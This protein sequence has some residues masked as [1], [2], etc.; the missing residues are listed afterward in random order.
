MEGGQKKDI[1]LT[2]GLDVKSSDQLV[3]VN[4]PLFQHN[5]QRY[6]GSMLPTSLR[7]EH[8]GYA[9]GWG[10][11]EFELD[12]VSVDTTPTG[13]TVIYNKLNNNPAYIFTIKSDDVSVGQIYFNGEDSVSSGDVSIA[14]DPEDYSIVTLSGDNS[15][16]E[17][18]ITINLITGEISYASSEWYVYEGSYNEALASDGSST[19][20]VVD[21][22][23]WVQFNA[24]VLQAKDATYNDTSLAAYSSCSDSTHTWKSSSGISWEIIH[25]VDTDE[26]TVNGETVEATRDDTTG[27]LSIPYNTQYSGTIDLSAKSSSFYF[28]I[29]DAYVSQSSK[30]ID[31]SNVTTEEFGNWSALLNGDTWLYPTESGSRSLTIQGSVPFWCGVVLS[32]GTQANGSSSVDLQELKAEGG[33]SITPSRAVFSA[34]LYVI[35]GEN[36]LLYD[37]VV[38]G[39]SGELWIGET[40]CLSEYGE[41]TSEELEVQD[42]IHVTLTYCACVFNRVSIDSEYEDTYQYTPMP[43][44]C[45]SIDSEYTDKSI[46]APWL[47]TSTRLSKK[48]KEGA[49]EEYVEVTFEGGFYHEVAWYTSSEEESIESGW[50]L[51]DEN[52]DPD[53]SSYPDVYADEQVIGDGSEYDSYVRLDFPYANYD[54]EVKSESIDG[55]SYICTDTSSEEEIASVMGRSIVD[56][57]IILERSTYDDGE[58]GKTYNFGSTGYLLPFFYS[59]ETG[60]ENDTRLLVNVNSSSSDAGSISEN[61]VTL[62]ITKGPLSGVKIISTVSNNTTSFNKTAGINM[63]Y[64]ATRVAQ[65]VEELRATY[66]A[67]GYTYV[68]YTAKNTG[69][70]SLSVTAYFTRFEGTS[71]VY[72]GDSR[73]GSYTDDTEECLSEY[74]SYYNIEPLSSW[75]KVVGLGDNTHKSSQLKTYLSVCF[76]GLF[77]YDVSLN[78]V[79]E[80]ATITSGTLLSAVNIE[81][82]PVV[83]L[84]EG[85]GFYIDRD[86]DNSSS[87]GV[88]TLFGVHKLNLTKSSS[89]VSN[90]TATIQMFLKPVSSY[91]LQIGSDSDCYIPGQVY[92]GASNRAYSGYNLTATTAGSSYENTSL[93]LSI[94][95]TV[96]AFNRITSGSVSWDKEDGS[97][98]FFSDCLPLA[99]SGITITSITFGSLTN[100]SA[101]NASALQLITLDIGGNSVVLRLNHVLS[102]GEASSVLTIDTAS[103][104]YEGYTFNFDLSNYSISSSGTDVVLSV[105][106]PLFYAI[107]ARLPYQYNYSSSISYDSDTGKYTIDGIEYDIVPVGSYAKGFTSS[108]NIYTFESDGGYSYTWSSE[109]GVATYGIETIETTD[110]GEA[111]TFSID[112]NEQLSFGFILQGV[113]RSNN[114]NVASF[115]DTDISFEYNGGVYTFS[116]DELLNSDSPSLLSFKYTD[117][118]DDSTTPSST[119]F[120]VQD[121]TDAYQFLRQ[122]WETDVS[123]ENFWWIDA[124]TVLELNKTSLV[125]KRKVSSFSDYDSET[126][127]DID[128]WGGDAWKDAAYFPRGDYLD[129]TVARYGVTCA[130]EGA[131]PRFWAVKVSSSNK[132]I[133]TFYTLTGSDYTWQFNKVSVTV[134]LSKVELGKALNSSALTLNTYSQLSATTI[135]YEAKFSGTVIGQHILFGI[136]QDNNFN[137]WALDISTDGTLNAIVQGYGFVGLDGSLTGGEIPSAFFDPS[138][139]F[140]SIVYPIDEIEQEDIEYVSSY[141]D[142]VSLD[143][144]GKVVGDCTQ[145]WYITSNLLNI[146]SHLT[147]NGESW[148]V[149]SLPITSNYICDYGSPSYGKRVISDASL[150]DKKLTELVTDDSFISEVEGIL[151]GLVT[152][153]I[154]GISPKVTYSLYL[155]QTCGQYA[156]VHY[157]SDTPNKQKDLTREDTSDNGFGEQGYEGRAYN[158]IGLA[159]DSNKEQE[160]D[161]IMAGYS[162]DFS[163]NIKGL[164][165]SVTVDK[166]WANSSLGMIVLII[167]GMSALTSTLSGVLDTLAVNKRANS[168]SASDFGKCFT[169]NFLYN[170]DNL[171]TMDKN[172]LGPVPTVQSAI[173]ASCSLDMFYSTSEGQK[174]QAGPGW[175]QHNMVAQCVA[176]SVTSCQ[177]ELQQIGMLWI[178]EGIGTLSAKYL[179]V[180]AQ[181]TWEAAVATAEST[182]EMTIMSTNSGWAIAVGIIAAAAVAYAA[183]GIYKVFS[184]FSDQ[185]IHSITGG[186]A[187]VEVK[188][189]ASKHDYTIEGKHKYGQKSEVFMWPCFGVD[190]DNAYTDETAEAVLVNHEWKLK[191]PLTSGTSWMGGEYSDIG[192]MV[193]EGVTTHTQADEV[194]ND[195]DGDV[196]YLISNLKGA[197]EEKTLPSDMACVIGSNSFLSPVPFRNE[198]ISASDPVFPTAPFQDYIID[199][200]WELSRTAAVGMTTWISCKDTKIIDGEASN[201]VVSDDF[202][203]VACPYTAIEVKRGCEQKYIR[204]WAITSN[205]IALNQSGFNCCYDEKAYHA[206]DGYGYRIVRWVGADGMNKEGAASQYSFIVNNRFKRSNKMPPNTFIGNFKGDPIIAL[207][208]TGEDWVSNQVTW[209]SRR[210]GLEA[211]TIGEDK[212]VR[213]YAVPVFSELVSTLP[214]VVKTISSI[215]LSV[216]DGITSLTTENRDLQSAY[217]APVSI[218]FAIGQDKY[219]FTDEYLCSLKVER[220]VTVVENL[221]P[222]LGLTYL[223]STPYEAYLY[224]QATRQY[225]T[226]AGGTSLTAVDTL[227][228]F[229]DVLYGRYDFVNQEVAIPCVATFVRLDKHVFDDEDERDNTIVPRLKEGSV[230]GEIAPPIETIYNMRSGFKTIS[231]PSGLC[232]QG[233][234]RCI[235]NRFVYSDYMKDQIINNAGNWSR[236]PREKYHPFR[237][238]GVEYERVD[239]DITSYISGWTHNPFLLVT[240]PLGVSS[241]VDCMFEWEITFAWPV[242]MDELYKEKQYACVNIMA[243]TFTPG[244]KVIPDRPTHVFLYRGL[245]TRTGNYGYYSF[246]YQSRC[247]AGN[248]ERLH[249]WSDQY[250]AVSGLR[251]E[252]KPV[253]EKRTEILTQQV[254]VQ[255]MQE[256]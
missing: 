96:A 215:N 115:S 63:W 43:F 245:F 121:V 205:A 226:Y 29:I 112:T 137:Q 158:A 98:L 187:K 138:I 191:V 256:I 210:V 123:V 33:G 135:A 35:P 142:F 109:T 198:N 212:D 80:D 125:V 161:A 236:V 162:D 177:W 188:N 34:S 209:G 168:I 51:T 201:I 22:L 2:S 211:G 150:W 84:V 10:V 106:V 94:K 75:S 110:V 239:E 20:N 128:D 104:T 14:H 141:K 120:A 19:L 3:P 48:V 47:D 69:W 204:P 64:R 40:E 77:Q 49:E 73:L 235:I 53:P 132:L 56:I 127:V 95:G 133:I 32:V 46:G 163:F 208:T 241:E 173:G 170:M 222:T 253:T 172:I 17:Y 183:A 72:V 179:Y 147:W 237:D 182:K 180:A 100:D 199:K 30:Y 27:E 233:P 149:V 66:E 71:T 62:E 252:Y 57:S 59:T 18:E 44:T 37:G 197:R 82:S 140:S 67:E 16:H 70:S 171:A 41:V 126:E 225:Y 200:G 90:T 7:Y 217:K 230:I 154:W 24:A 54:I 234:N 228:R 189:A 153:H 130:Y 129:N 220:G 92:Y 55:G 42:D 117:T 178:I 65:F 76:N 5:R 8:N 207:T 240:S 175:V 122:A 91:Y 23:S 184:D 36:F 25:D 45:D 165:Q 250:I 102:E 124:D 114:V 255:D 190:T 243:E 113:Y 52:G 238:Y 50:Y 93:S 78:D 193:F 174:I 119:T 9:A 247:G 181:I 214:A 86:Y 116:Y 176:Q 185:L 99:T 11:Y 26:T 103:I 227:E 134:A 88:C 192:T 157:N 143:A 148:S 244:G 249:I 12:Q 221:V 166:P 89:S 136:H 1:P 203:G 254:D 151:A 4:T 242:E 224:S 21:L 107:T 85:T 223:G 31:T 6:Q 246:R 248:R 87:E 194:I 13:Y 146:V 39:H 213:R 164:R 145:Q 232:Y 231:L 167:E 83:S 79:N 202:C 61:S 160:V 68:S 74:N 169:Q 195:F 186:S 229:R 152:C 218:D 28:Q 219:R 97:H 60:E 216:I 155:Q 251:V 196:A 15:G 159:V 101:G 105:V 131:T 139:G 118:R 58:T 206:F 38:S 144:S 156:Y 108:N 81:T 111:E